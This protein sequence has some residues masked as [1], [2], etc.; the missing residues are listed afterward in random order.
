MTGL[1]SRLD[2][3]RWAKEGIFAAC[4]LVARLG[5]DRWASSP[6]AILGYHSHSPRGRYGVDARRFER[7]VSFV[8][9]RFRTVRLDELIERPSDDAEPLVC[10]TFDDGYRDNHEVT[11]PV[12]E[13][14]G[15]KGTFFLIPSLFGGRLRTAHGEEPLMT[16]EQ[17]REI[18][19]LGHEIGSHTLTHAVLTRVPAAEARREIRDSKRR[20]EDLL[21]VPVTCFSYP[22]GKSDT[23]T[24]AMA[25]EAGYRA[26][27]TT[28]EALV[29]RVADPFEL[30][31]LAVDRSVGGIQF[32]ARLSHA[33]DVY[34]GLLGRRS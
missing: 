14:F 22:L 23:A 20:L 18:A 7:Q 5:P 21:S 26:A 25:R 3:R 16:L 10:L 34:N 4:D 2:H 12:L 1:P 17:A 28:S 24:K 19:A 6:R 30:P 15:V 27:V 32:R 13:R 33:M 31:R 8:A 29:P 9:S 11:L